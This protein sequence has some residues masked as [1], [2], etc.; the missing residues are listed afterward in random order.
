MDRLGPWEDFVVD[1]VALCQMRGG[2]KDWWARKQQALTDRLYACLAT[3]SAMILMLRVSTL[4]S[5]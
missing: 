3:A 4:T 1:A 2:V 5:V